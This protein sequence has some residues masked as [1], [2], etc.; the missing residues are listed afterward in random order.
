MYIAPNSI[1]KLCNN[2]PIDNTYRN[3]LWFD[4]E[5][6][7]LTYFNGKAK[8]TFNAQ[9]YQRANRGTLKVSIAVEN[10]YDCNYLMFQ[11]TSFGNKWFYGFITNVEYI[12]NDV[13]RVTYEIDVMQ[14][15][16]FNY[17]LDTNFV[18]REHIVDDTIGANIIP[19]GLE[20][21]EYVYE[22]TNYGLVHTKWDIVFACTFDVTLT[23][24]TGNLMDDKIYTGLKYNVFPL[25][26]IN[27]AIGGT[28]SSNVSA[29]NDFISNAVGANLVDGFVSVYM[30]P[31]QYTGIVTSGAS[32]VSMGSMTFRGV[33]IYTGN[34]GTSYIRNNKMY[35]YPYSFIIADNQQGKDSIYRYEDFSLT[36]GRAVFA[37]LGSNTPDAVEMYIPK[38]HKGRTYN[39]SEALVSDVAIPCSFNVDAYKAFLAQSL[40]AHI[41]DAPSQIVNMPMQ[42]VEL[43]SSNSF[44]G[45]LL[46][47]IARGFG[48]EKSSLTGTKQLYDIKSISDITDYDIT[49]AGIGAAL[50]GNSAVYRDLASLYDHRTKAAG[51]VGNTVGNILVST[52]VFGTK[53]MQMHIKPEFARCIDDYFSMFGYA[54]NKVKVPNRSSRPHWNYVQLKNTHIEG[55]IPFDHETV[56]CAIYD[57]GITFW[58]NPS[59]VGDYTLDNRPT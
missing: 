49:K 44:I 48:K 51:N 12:S 46:D 18:S 13:S 33:P 24:A 27:E 21:G 52:D 34:F 50:T 17:T 8:Y 4:N 56:I 10:I 26:Y 54:T 58:K 55:A 31:H 20:T 42:N 53:L 7:Q 35:T 40:T 14:T 41:I 6:A 39:H 11:N 30:V 28:I 36:D 2:V 23:N 9:S 25:N 43:I 15:W 29:I 19:E 3:T 32:P 57:R 47:G 16:F 1:I 38:D 22:A 45:Q 5:A 59:E 37:A